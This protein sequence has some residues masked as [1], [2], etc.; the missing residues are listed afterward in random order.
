MTLKLI[1]ISLGILICPNLN[2]YILARIKMKKKDL[3]TLSI[4]INL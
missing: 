2:I 3:L 1:H 4:L